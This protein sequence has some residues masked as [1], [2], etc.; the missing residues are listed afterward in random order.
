MKIYTKRGDA[1]VTDLYDGS[2]AEKSDSIFNALGSIDELSSHIGMLI[3][4]IR[5]Y[6]MDDHTITFLRN[7]QQDLLN[8][9][10]IIATP[11]PKEDQRLPEITEDHVKKIETSIDNIDTVLKPLTVFIK[12]GGVNIIESQ[13][14]ICRTVCRRAERDIVGCHNDGSCLNKYMNRLSDYFFT[15]ARF[16]SECC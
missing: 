16:K 8:I 9:G 4:H 3:L 13:A 10:S 15:F 2:R 11:N 6:S 1:G 5:Q 14:H 7:V 12:V